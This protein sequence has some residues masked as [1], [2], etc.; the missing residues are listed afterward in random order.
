MATLKQLEKALKSIGWEIGGH[1]G[2]WIIDH[3]RKRT[4]WRFNGEAIDWHSGF[5]KNKFDGSIYFRLDQCEIETNIDESGGAVHLTVKGT[6]SVFV[7]FYN[8]DNLKD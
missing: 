2:N 6:K 3:N 8:H 4:N 5:G 1:R 7:S